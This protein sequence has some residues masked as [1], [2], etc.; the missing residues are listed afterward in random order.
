MKDNIVDFV[1]IRNKKIEKEKQ[2][3]LTSYTIE[4]ADELCGEITE[5]LL[6]YLDEEG[7][8]DINTANETDFYTN[9]ISFFYETLKSLIY[10]SDNEYHPFQNM[11]YT[12]FELDQNEED[13][14]QLCFEFYEMVDK[15]E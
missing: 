4:L 11:A 3:K 12:L 14:S 15:D 9:D 13:S 5:D 2:P 1:S 10:K 7:I 6:L 8:L